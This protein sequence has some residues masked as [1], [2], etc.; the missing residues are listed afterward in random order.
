MPDYEAY[1]PITAG[2]VDEQ[3]AV[4]LLHE[5]KTMFIFSFPFV[6]VTEDLSTLRRDNPFLLPAILAVTS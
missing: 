5:F 2:V 6:L 4:L 1:D 3:H